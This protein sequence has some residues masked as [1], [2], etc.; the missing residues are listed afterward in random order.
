[1]LQ[2][3]GFC[4]LFLR[5]FQTWDDQDFCLECTADQGSTVFSQDSTQGCKGCYQDS[6]GGHQVDK[7]GGYVNTQY[8][9]EHGHLYDVLGRPV[10]EA[11]DSMIMCMLSVS[12][13][14]AFALFD[15]RYIFLYSD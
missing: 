15:P 10:A 3:W 5:V 2:L 4:S 7:I 1:M 6:R 14:L 8:G 13:Q 11:L 12:H 9:S